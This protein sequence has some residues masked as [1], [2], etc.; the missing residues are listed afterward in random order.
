M[1]KA[2]VLG[3]AGSFGKEIAK[4]LVNNGYEIIGTY[5]L[6]FPSDD[7]FYMQKNI[8]LFQLSFDIRG[9][10]DNFCDKINNLGKIDLVINTVANNLKFNRFEKI[11]IKDFEED[12]GVNCINNIYF[13]QKILSKLN[14]G[15]N[16]VFILTEMVFGEPPSYF[17]SYVTSKYALLGFMKSLAGEFKQ[18]EIR[19]NGVSPGM[20][21]TKFILGLPSFIKEKYK[22]SSPLKSLVKPSEVAN[23]ILKIISDQSINGQN[24][25][26][27]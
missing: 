16:V 1:K 21:D 24:I 8:K 27:N 10:I 9:S 7:S 11:N 3:I 26:V 5:H 17:S 13:L 2:I 6:R 23:A 18:K 12:M 4:V 19:V 20:A 14:E 25:L 15:A 22:Q